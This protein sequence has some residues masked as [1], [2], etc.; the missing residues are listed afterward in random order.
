MGML[1]YSMCEMTHFNSPW[2]GFL[3]INSV[4]LERLPG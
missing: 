1:Y 4:A 2:K 3:P